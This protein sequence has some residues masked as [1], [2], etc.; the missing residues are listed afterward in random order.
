MF[1]ILVSFQAV[2]HP[3]TATVALSICS[4]ESQKTFDDRARRGGDV[5]PVATRYPWKKW[6]DE[7]NRYQW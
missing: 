4:H 7:Y 6:D 3:K 1:P 2:S 5:A